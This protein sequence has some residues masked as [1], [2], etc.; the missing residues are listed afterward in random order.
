MNGQNICDIVANYLCGMVN[1]ESIR[2]PFKI[3]ALMKKKKNYAV[4]LKT[5]PM[6][7]IT[8]WEVS[9]GISH[10]LTGSCQHPIATQ[11]RRGLHRNQY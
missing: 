4:I 5:F 6:S 7:S 3:Y 8:A 2:A 10:A 11:Q 9:T 1:N